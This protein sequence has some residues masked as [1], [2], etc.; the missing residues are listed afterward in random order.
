MLW[1]FIRNGLGDFS[2]ILQNF[3]HL[4]RFSDSVDAT[5]ALSRLKG[6]VTASA[7]HFSVSNMASDS[8]P[9][10]LKLAIYSLKGRFGKWKSTKVSKG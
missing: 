6:Q 9:G 8:N 4:L 10:T 2:A 7:G 5:S 1:P 3:A